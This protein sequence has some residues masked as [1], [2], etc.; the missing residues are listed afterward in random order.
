MTGCAISTDARSPRPIL[1][2]E[3]TSTAKCTRIIEA[4]AA[5]NVSS[6]GSSTPPIDLTTPNLIELEAMV[7]RATQLGL[8]SPQ[9]VPA[10]PSPAASLSANGSEVE[11]TET[12]EYIRSLC[13]SLAPFFAVFLVTMGERG[14]LSATPSTAGT[15]S[16][17]R[18][19]FTHH[20]PPP[21]SRGG[22]EGKL[23]V[24]STTGAGDTF[25]GAILAGLCLRLRRSPL[26]TSATLS[27]E[28]LE[29]LVQLG[30]RAAILTLQS[31]EAVAEDLSGALFGAWAAG[32]TEGEWRAR[33]LES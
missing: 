17:R 23:N 10:P 27:P 28:A 32:G 13:E 20:P 3:P 5:L 4:L 21:T 29:E 31:Q 26:D 8:I 18:L 6:S 22:P 15:S 24:V 2:F 14:V 19:H 16:S 25:A 30:Q 11:G 9:E 33:G 1:F 12:Q 7:A